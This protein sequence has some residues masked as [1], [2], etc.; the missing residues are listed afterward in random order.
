MSD[1]WEIFDHLRAEFDA[2]YE[3]GSWFLVK[4]QKLIK[5]DGRRFS[6][7]PNGHPVVIANRYNPRRH[8]PNVTGYPRSASV[9]GG[10][11]HEAHLPHSGQLGCIINR[12][13]WVKLHIPVAISS[14]EVNASTFSCCEE[15]NSKLMRKIK[16][17]R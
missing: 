1:N 13:G 2:P 15:T 16:G 5:R 14:A 8:G 7:D 17:V 11:T 12:T 9:P 3:I 10:L 6:N 4:N